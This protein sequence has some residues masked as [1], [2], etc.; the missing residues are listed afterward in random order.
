MRGETHNSTDPRRRRLDELF[1]DEPHLSATMKARRL[2]EK[3]RELEGEPDLAA[4][5]LPATAYVG[6]LPGS[7]RSAE[8]PRVERPVGGS[9]LT[10]EQAASLCRGGSRDG[11]S[12]ERIARLR[13]AVLEPWVEDMRRHGPRWIA[14]G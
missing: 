9:L 6:S 5:G 11:A 14:E 4:Q 7:A 8:V 2:H 1:A 10:L 12:S 3:L 13:Q